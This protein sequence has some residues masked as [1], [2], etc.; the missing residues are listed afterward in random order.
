MRGGYGYGSR[1]ASRMINIAVFSEAGISNR[2]KYRGTRVSSQ[3][4]R[5]VAEGFYDLFGCRLPSRGRH[6]PVSPGTPRTSLV[7][8]NRND[9]PDNFRRPLRSWPAWSPKKRSHRRKLERGAI[10]RRKRISTLGFHRVAP[11]IPVRQFMDI[12]WMKVSCCSN[13]IIW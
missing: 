6:T 7:R 12:Q 2:P 3:E 1:D 9:Q 11:L 4:H 5:R 8:S 10:P 13:R